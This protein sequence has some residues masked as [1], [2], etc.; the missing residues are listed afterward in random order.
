MANETPPRPA[1]RKSVKEDT[2]VL[3]IVKHYFKCAGAVVAI[4]GFGYWQFSPAWLLL[5]LVAYVW[6]EKKNKENQKKIEISQQA[7][8]NEQAAILARVEDLP[9]WV[10]SVYL[11]FS[12]NWYMCT[13]TARFAGSNPSPPMARCQFIE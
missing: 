9:S 5:G 3:N 8:K 1:A 2:L 7:A 13:V 10:S 12:T 6:K 11:Q 4:W